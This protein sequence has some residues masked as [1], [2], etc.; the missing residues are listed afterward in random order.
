MPQQGLGQK[1]YDKTTSSKIVRGSF[2]S[3][4][5]VFTAKVINGSDALY[6][7]GIDKLRFLQARFQQV[8]S[9]YWKILIHPCQVSHAGQEFF[10]ETF[11]CLFVCFS[12]VVFLRSQLKYPYK[13][14]CLILGVFCSC[15]P[16]SGFLE[17]FSEHLTPTT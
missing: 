6:S 4:A 5:K 11:F 16:S 2:I 9:T 10:L 1:H 3:G 14:K 12:L 7:F 17:C 8:I 15:A 13:L